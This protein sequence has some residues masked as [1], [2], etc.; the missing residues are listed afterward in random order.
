MQ[1]FWSSVSTAL[2]ST[3]AELIFWRKPMTN[4]AYQRKSANKQ[5]WSTN[6]LSQADC[7][8]HSAV[9]SMIKHAEHMTL[10]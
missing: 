1:D 7:G 6:F 4:K 3:A 8:G 2:I 5:G 9:V 10:I